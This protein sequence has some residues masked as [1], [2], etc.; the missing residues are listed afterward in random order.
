MCA[1]S[2][3]RAQGALS[4]AD[5]IRRGIP[6]QDVYA[7]LGAPQFNASVLAS[8]EIYVRYEGYLKKNREQI[9]RAK[10]YENKLLPEDADYSQIEGLRLEAREKL[11]KVKPRSLGQAS[12]ISGVNPAD[13]AVLTVWLS[14]KKQ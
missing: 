3:E 13:V 11:N 8:A 6:A 9:V 2:F 4:Y 10:K 7:A 1:N 12:R 14:M 5:L